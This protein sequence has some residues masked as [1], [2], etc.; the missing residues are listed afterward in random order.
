MRRIKHAETGMGKK[1]SA[2][3]SV[4]CIMDLHKKEFSFPLKNMYDR[5]ITLYQELYYKTAILPFLKKIRQDKTKRLLL[6][7]LDLKSEML[8]QKDNIPY[9]SMRHITENLW[10]YEAGKKAM[11]YL[12]ELEKIFTRQHILHTYKGIDL[13]DM[14]RKDIWR[15]YLFIMV[16][17]IDTLHALVHEYSPDTIVIFNRTSPFQK[18]LKKVA[19]AYPRIRVIDKTMLF[20]R[21]G[22]KIKKVTL[23]HIVKYNVP[24]W[25]R[26]PRPSSFTLQQPPMHEGRKKPGLKAQKRAQRVLITHNTIHPKKVLLWAQ[27]LTKEYAVC[28]VGVSQDKDAFQKHHIL[29]RHL[30]EYINEDV[31]RCLR[32]N[33]RYFREKEPRLAKLEKNHPFVQSIIYKKVLLWDNLEELFSFLYNARFYE[34]S[35]YIELFE[36]MIAVEKPDI[37]MTVD[38]LSVY[39]RTLCAVARKA[40]IP[41]LIVQPGHYGK[42]VISDSTQATR[43]LV[44]GQSTKDDLV[45][46]GMAPEKITLI[47]IPED[48]A[49]EDPKK[50]REEVIQRYHLS[51]GK[52][53]FLFT[54]QALPENLN[55]PLFDTVY[56]AMHAC[57]EI[58]FITKLHPAEKPELHQQFIAK[59]KVQNV[60]LVPHGECPLTTLLQGAN[61]LLNFY[62]TIRFEALF[63]GKF[64]ISINV[65]KIPDDFLPAPVDEIIMTAK[66]YEELVSL[67]KKVNA[68]KSDERERI[69][70]ASK[71]YVSARGKEACTR[72]VHEVRALLT[73]HQKL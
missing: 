32:K 55:I 42:T 63:L 61:C 27:E 9:I 17:L 48:Y 28:F 54:S 64:L 26:S 53:I 29:F 15:S 60:I 31:V 33:M 8:L 14:T 1:N 37:I 13:I 58:Q 16:N 45:A 4:C 71:I 7:T 11:N 25:I 12:N 52:K 34:I 35:A 72:I 70:K 39:G 66:S 21:A 6:F 23:R 69:L 20:H 2:R 50:A 44:Y 43:I 36:K 49:D 62:S 51:K 65:N 30:R 3:T 22:E 24:A 68:K 56:K 18:I 59:F 40:H 46:A 10:D 19:A 47:G 67:I 73:T 38:D 5:S 57:P 41:C